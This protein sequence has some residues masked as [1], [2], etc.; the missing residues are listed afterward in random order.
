MVWAKF[1]YFAYIAFA[2]TQSVSFKNEVKMMLEL[3][4]SYLPPSLIPRH[5]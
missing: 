4:K 5:T 3:K 2:A 1:F